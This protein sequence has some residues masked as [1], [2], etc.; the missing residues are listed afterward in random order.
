MPKNPPPDVFFFFS[1]SSFVFFSSSFFIIVLFLLLS[2]FSFSSSTSFIIISSLLLLFCLSSSNILGKSFIFEYCFKCSSNNR[3]YILIS[4]SSLGF[5]IKLYSDFK[6]FKYIL[7]KH[8]ISKVNPS[9]SNTSGI[10]LNILKII[11]IIL[12]SNSKLMFIS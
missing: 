8:D 11:F 1:L 6:I 4:Y 3:I 9:L 12:S 5:I 7:C 10:S 2:S